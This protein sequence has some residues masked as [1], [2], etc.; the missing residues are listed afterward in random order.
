MS[1]TTYYCLYCRAQHPRE[2]MRHVATKTGKRWRCVMSIEAAKADVAKREEYG[3]KV[4]EANKEELRAKL[5]V[6]GK[7][8]PKGAL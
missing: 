2:E 4:S 8:E 1:S 3:R 5:R 7:A 6:R